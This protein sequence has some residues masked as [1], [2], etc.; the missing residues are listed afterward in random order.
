MPRRANPERNSYSYCVR[1]IGAVRVG[2][3]GDMGCLLAR[4][5]NLAILG[6]ND[7]HYDSSVLEIALANVDVEAVALLLKNGANIDILTLTSDKINL[8]VKALL[9][10]NAV[11]IDRTFKTAVGEISVLGHAVYNRDVVRARLLLEKGA[12][13]NQCFLQDFQSSLL[14]LAAETSHE[15][16]VRCLLDHNIDT[17]ILNENGQTAEVY[18]SRLEMPQPNLIRIFNEHPKEKLFIQAVCSG[19]IIEAQSLVDQNAFLVHTRVSI[20]TEKEMTMLEFTV[21]LRNLDVTSLL[22]ENGADVNQRLARSSETLAHL[23]LRN[24]D[25]PMLLCLQKYNIDMTQIRDERIT[26]QRYEAIM[27]GDL[28]AN[29]VYDNDRTVVAERFASD[30]TRSRWRSRHRRVYG[31]EQEVGAPGGCCAMM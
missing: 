3:I 7:S 24:S 15:L 1:M 10:E 30:A 28:M 22:L 31:E 19:N 12:N 16:M 14:H 26:A 6:E 2:D 29:E 8:V 21:G 18:V 5:P 4:S 23:A 11:N 17:S 13:V 27:S 9:L 25:K 20:G